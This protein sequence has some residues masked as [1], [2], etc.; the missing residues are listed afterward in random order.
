[1]RQ[2]VFGNTSLSQFD[3]IVIGSGAGG[4]PVAYVLATNGMK[5]LVLE[6]GP[7]HLDFLDDPAQH[8]GAAVLERRAQD[9]APQLHRDRRSRRAAHVAHQPKPTAIASTR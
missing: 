2:T 3:V 8:T 4:G 7:C 5:V 6:A 9:R 1:M